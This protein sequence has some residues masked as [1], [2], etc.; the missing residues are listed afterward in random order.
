MAALRTSACTWTRS[1]P[2]WCAP[3]RVCIGPSGL[4]RVC[5]PAACF[6]CSYLQAPLSWRS[7]ACVCLQEAAPSSA[8]SSEASA[9]QQVCWVM[10]AQ[11]GR[12]GGTEGHALLQAGR[13]KL[14]RCEL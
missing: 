11:G 6:S 1:Q 8:P 7:V 13:C 5:M 4:L 14:I 2:S 3:A 12:V 9:L 10:G